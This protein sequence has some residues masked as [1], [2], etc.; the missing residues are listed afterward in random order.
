[1]LLCGNCCCFGGCC[2]CCFV[3]FVSL[4]PIVSVSPVF[5]SL[6]SILCTASPALI[7]L[8][9][10]LCLF[11]SPYACQ[12]LPMSLFVCLSLLQLLRYNY[13]SPR[14]SPRVSLLALHRQCQ[15]L[16]AQFV[17]DEYGKQSP[18][19]TT[20]CLALLWFSLLPFSRVS[21][22]SSGLLWA[23][24]LGIEGLSG[25]CLVQPVPLIGLAVLLQLLHACMSCVRGS[26]GFR[27]GATPVIGLL[28]PR[29]GS[30]RWYRRLPRDRSGCSTQTPP[31]S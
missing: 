3:S 8:C 21:F 17:R 19:F 4:Y 7:F 28:L 6:P 18:L 25:V 14:P 29:G 10:S 30:S 26:A 15:I 9:L 13:Q 31:G 22:A 24:G 11:I 12:H 1:M 27:G 23:Q 2:V 16:D 5:S 20:L